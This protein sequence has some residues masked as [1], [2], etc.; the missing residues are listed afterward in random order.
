MIKCP[1]CRVDMEKLTNGKYF[2]DSCPKC[3][4]VFLDKEEL[5]IV[6]KMSFFHYVA[7]YFKKQKPG[8]V[9]W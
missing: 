6:N 8:P 2:I 4:G 1:K 7:D 3:R 9:R 5:V